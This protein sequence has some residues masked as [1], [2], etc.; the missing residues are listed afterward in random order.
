MKFVQLQSDNCVFF[1][2]DLI[3]AIYVDDMII[4]DREIDE[5]NKFKLDMSKIFKFK[6]LNEIKTILGINITFKNLRIIQN[7]EQNNHKLTNTLI[8]EK[9][10]LINFVDLNLYRKAIGSLIYLMTST[11]PDI[12]YAIGV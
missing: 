9:E 3:I 10:N 11:R 5:I 4:A 1:N 6:D 7:Q 12:N 8:H 2:N